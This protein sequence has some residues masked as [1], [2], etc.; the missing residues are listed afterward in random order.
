MSKIPECLYRYISIKT[1]EK[2]NYFISFL[3]NNEMHL[4]NPLKFNDPYDCSPGFNFKDENINNTKQFLSEIYDK[5]GNS[6]SK[7]TLTDEALRH[8]QSNE[9]EQNNIN[10]VIRG[11][12][13]RLNEKNMGVYCLTER[14]YNYLPMWAYY[15]DNHKGLV[16]KLYTQDGIINES[17]TERLPIYKVAYNKNLPKPSELSTDS[18][19][20][21]IKT[22]S[23]RK[24]ENWAHEK[25][26]RVIAPKKLYGSKIKYH[27]AIIEAI[28][29][30]A[31]IDKE[32][33]QKI[34]DILSKNDFQHV[35]CFDLEQDSSTFIL[36]PIP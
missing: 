34:I 30:G 33:Q 36:N 22:L 8:L 28:Y 16:L 6:E 11:Y 1:E 10:K 32:K 31:Q 18:E 9:N 7:K 24:S 12:I 29:F 14:D 19:H 4:S 5:N 27:K 25:E 35:K 21:Y 2:L 20:K 17:E 3:E 23:T 15:G 13:K 26:W